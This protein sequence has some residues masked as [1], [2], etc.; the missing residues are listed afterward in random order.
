MV[1]TQL[2]PLSVWLA[3]RRYP[4][5]DSVGGESGQFLRKFLMCFYRRSAI[6]HQLIAF[7]PD[8]CVRRWARC[9]G[10]TECG[11]EQHQDLEQGCGPSCRGPCKKH[12]EQVLVFPRPRYLSP[13][14]SFVAS[15]HSIVEMPQQLTPVSYHRAFEGYS[16]EWDEMS[17]DVETAFTLTLAHGGK[18]SS[19]SNNKARSGDAHKDDQA[20][21]PEPA[22]GHGIPGSP[23]RST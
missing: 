14:S 6:A 20:A 22:E 18:S 19:G 11:R 3:Q 16:A 12:K 13:H 23:P 5:R 4:N 7:P 15:R 10:G 2:R 8:V 17:S 21:R 1:R 9:R